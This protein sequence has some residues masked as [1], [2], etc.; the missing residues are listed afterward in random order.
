MD[1]NFR[2]IE[3]KWQQQWKEKKVYAVSNASDKPKYYVLDMF[4]YP[5]GAG[6]H[7]GHP[8]GYISSDIYS[9]YKRLKGFNVLHPMGFDAFG[10]PAEQYAIDHGIHPAVSTEANINTFRRQLDNIGF[11]FDWDRELRTCDPKY[12]KWTQWIFLQ[13]FDSWFNRK[14]QKAQRIDE[15]VKIFN[16]EGNKTHSFPNN[17]YQLKAGENSFTAKEWKSYDEGTKEDLLM[18]YRLAYLAYSDVNWCEALGTVLAN[19]E[20]ING[21]SYRG[22]FPVVKKKMRQWSLRIT[23]YAERLLKG[24]EE[25]DFSE[26]MK[27][28]QRN[29]IGKSFGAEISFAIKIPGRGADSQAGDARELVL[30]VFTTRPDTIFG[31]DFMVVAP[32]HEIVKEITSKEQQSPIDEYLE[33]VKGRSEVERMAEVKKITGCFTGAYA[34]NP[35]NGREI[36]VWISEYVLAGYGTGAIMGVPCGDERD[37]KFAKHFGIPITNIIGQHYNGEEANATKEAILQNSDFLNGILMKDAIQVVIDRI[38]QSGIGKRQINYKMRDAGWSRQRYWGEPFPIIFRDDVPYPMNSKDLPLELPP[39]DEFRS[40]GTGEGPLANAMDWVFI[41]EREKRD[42]NTMPTHAGAAWYFLRFMDPHNDSVFAD[43][44]TLDYWGQVDVYIGGAEHA[45]AHLLYARLWV[46][47]LSDLGYLNFDEPFK[48]L[49]NQGKIT[50]DSRFVYR[51]DSMGG[52]DPD[53]KI[54][55]GIVSSHDFPLFISYEYVRKIQEG[56]MIKK[57]LVEV[58]NRAVPGYF[59]V[60]DSTDYSTVTIS[61]LHVDVNIVDG[62]ILNTVAFRNWKPDFSNAGF[63]LND[64][65]FSSS[66]VGGQ[67]GAYT[68][69]AAIEK[70]SKSYFNVV[71]PDAVVEKYGADTFRMYEMFLGPLEAS[72]PWDIKGIEG[73]HRFLRKLWRL[74]VHEEKGLIVKSE[75]ATDVEWKALYKT[76]RK[77]EEDTERFSFNTAVSSFM[78]G[79][80]ELSDLKCHKKE[81]LEKLLVALTPYAPHV[82]EELWHL[83]GNKETVLDAAYPIIEEKYLVES[84]KNYPVAVNG[85]TRTELNIALEATQQQ[86]EELVLNN[87]VVKRWLEGKPP[88]KVIYVKGRMVN[89]VI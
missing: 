23:E 87:D 37:H 44:K 36:P 1:Y 59:E 65:S 5:S 81:V 76:L 38:E 82:S 55:T 72:K 19:D 3:K 77:V 2:A 79:V 85:K 34:L 47:V 45:V 40:S 80:N 24:L 56:E 68:C 20:V 22:G 51:V 43:R 83:L 17:K 66:T 58:I 50:G 61:P 15:L 31:V 4:P 75:K 69:G 32:E 63:I 54:K 89:I 26:S 28:I 53:R 70:M 88:K 8:L 33:Y 84:S 39:M 67:K 16:E 11:S 73:V 41:N 25:I 35:F 49:I 9:R 86:V 74:Y 10:L 52:L 78:I 13:L 12:Y 27:E 57:E 30:N 60:S 42:T 6:L 62:L 64:G 14:T 46:K 71:N 48:K 7:V 21:V 18:Q 29:W